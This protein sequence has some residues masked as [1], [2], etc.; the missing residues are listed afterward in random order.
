MGSGVNAV[1]PSSV[2]VLVLEPS[3]APT[4]TPSNVNDMAGATT[5]VQ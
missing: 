4:N 1:G 3:V 2:K 5:L